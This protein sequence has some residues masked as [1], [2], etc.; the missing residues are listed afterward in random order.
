MLITQAVFSLDPSAGSTTELT[1]RRPDA[2]IPE[3][4]VTKAST[5]LW[6]EIEH[7]A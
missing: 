6:K 3:P 5:G 7:G 1:L 2:F 4:T